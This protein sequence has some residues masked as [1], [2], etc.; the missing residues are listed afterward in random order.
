MNTSLEHLFC[1]QGPTQCLFPINGRRPDVPNHCRNDSNTDG[2]GN[3]LVFLSKWLGWPWFVVG[4]VIFIVVANSKPTCRCWFLF[5]PDL[6]DSAPL[7]V[8]F[9]QGVKLV[10][11][12][13]KGSWIFE[14]TLPKAVCH[15]KKESQQSDF[16][17]AAAGIITPM[18][19]ARVPR[20]LPTDVGLLPVWHVTLIL[21][22]RRRSTYLL[23][24]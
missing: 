20:H 8:K 18:P 2:F 13:C 3:L 6:F 14:A 10:S 22:A 1:K 23:H 12:C 9:E 19:K 11:C 24:T 17:M 16:G 7:S 15:Q 21:Y 4:C 5:P